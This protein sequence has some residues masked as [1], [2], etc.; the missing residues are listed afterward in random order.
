LP[1]ATLEVLRS[2]AF[3]YQ[4]FVKQLMKHG[5][6]VMMLRNGTVIIGSWQQDLLEGRAI[7][8]TSL[9]CRVLAQFVQGRF[10]G[11]ALATYR[12]RL[13]KC[14][15]FFEGHL[16]GEKLTFDGSE[17]MWVSSKCAYDGKLLA[18]THVEKGSLTEPPS[19]LQSE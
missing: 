8:Y 1:V 12:Q 4:G 17:G 14:L 13:V 15:L 11:W 7:I 5:E 19:F 10:N 18:I 3:I 16:D 2:E 6:G 9:G